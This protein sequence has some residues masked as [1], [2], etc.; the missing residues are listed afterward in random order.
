METSIYARTSRVGFALFVLISASNLFAASPSVTAV[1][2]DSQPDVGQMVQ[3]EIKVSGAQS[4]N[5]PQAISIDGLEI[6]QT[7]TSRQF[8]MHNFDV[9]SSV[10][11]NYT[12]MPVKAGRFKIPPQTVRVG[13]DSLKT[14]ELELN[15]GQGSSGR[16]SA[17][18]GSSQSGQ[19]SVGSKA[20]FA[21]LVIAKKDAYVG[22]MIPAEIRLGFDARARGRLQDGP[23]LSAQ[24]FTTQKLQ[25]P[26]EN[27]ETIGGRTYQVL[28][29]KTALAAA[30]AG[31]FELGPV[32]AKAMVVMPRRP[33]TQPRNPRTRPRSPLD[34]FNLD[35][36][37]SDP[38]FADPFGSMGGER[39]ELPIKSETV[40]LNIK[41]LPPN[42]PP[43]FSGAVGRFTMNVD[44][45]P[46][47]VQVG[48]PITLTSTITG[49][50]NFDRMT[51]PVLEDERGWHKYPPS[52]K[53]KQDDDVGLSGEKTF[54][55]VIAPNE[56]KSAVPPL[57]FAYFD[58][59]KESYVSLRSEP[60][61]ISVQG[62]AAP[63]QSAASA[64]NAQRPAA[65]P[66]ATIGITPS[67]TAKPQD[68]LYQMN[69]LG[70]VRS[71]RPM[72][73]RT[74]FWIAQLAPLILLL[75]F[76]GWKIRRARAG[77][78][79]A[80]RI[81]ARQQEMSRLLRELRRGDVSPQVYF[82]QATRVVQLKTAA[83]KN[84]SPNAVDAETAAKAFDL[85]END[86][87]QLRKLF[88]RK[89]ELSFSGNGGNGADKISNSEREEVLRLVESLTT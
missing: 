15:V 85:G 24:G 28:T 29:F 7:G 74:Q 25:Q 2:S 49:R 72:Y 12:I 26:R 43:N 35:D 55:M 20:A 13:N 53:F 83:A 37:F 79:E 1:L 81:A 27:L 8:E 68:I 41:P 84:M 71:F 31:K 14:P 88:E 42:A 58:P 11:Y 6:H 80:Q 63:A 64:P 73:A 33:S 22:E 5:V 86:R 77:D 52:S 17:T 82:S 65:T 34:L 40:S 18:V 59:A 10:T 56:Q 54:E 51:A 61:P 9:S 16:S 21:E 75:G 19:T 66:S 36:P 38:F 23:E 62:G 78:R 57:V 70:A 60:V 76:I 48:D 89:D 3:L 67:P 46:K 44:A 47:T 4:A 69:D 50:G 30:R 45:K 87:A 32:T 39:V